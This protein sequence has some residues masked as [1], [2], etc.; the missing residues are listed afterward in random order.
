MLIFASG[1]SE[2]T[3]IR[4]PQQQAHKCEYCFKMYAKE[5]AYIDKCYHP[6]LYDDFTF[7]EKLLYTTEKTCDTC[8]NVLHKRD[9]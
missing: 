6:V 9:Y 8:T 7:S 3:H 2:P 5:T 4:F 1:A